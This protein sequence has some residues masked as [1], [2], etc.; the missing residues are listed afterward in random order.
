MHFADIF[1]TSAMSAGA[2]LRLTFF[3]ALGLLASLWTSLKA[4]GECGGGP[5]R[6]RRLER[7]MKNE[8]EVSGMETYLAFFGGEGGTKTL[9]RRRSNCVWRGGK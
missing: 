2:M 9:L 8:I 3:D 5:L 7:K 4:M 6:A 1:L